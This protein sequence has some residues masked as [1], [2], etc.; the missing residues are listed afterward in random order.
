MR[1]RERLAVEQVSFLSAGAGGLGEPQGRGG[2]QVSSGTLGVSP[3]PPEMLRAR[4]SSPLAC[5]HVLLSLGRLRCLPGNHMP[6]TAI[7][8]HPAASQTLGLLSYC[9]PWHNRL[10]HWAENFQS[11]ASCHLALELVGASGVWFCARLSESQGNPHIQ[12]SGTCEGLPEACSFPRRAAGCVCR[13][14]EQPSMQGRWAR[15]GL[16]AQDG[17]EV[18]P[19]CL[20]PRSW[21]YPG[22]VW[23]QGGHSH[24]LPPH[25]LPW[26]TGSGTVRSGS[27]R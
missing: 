22:N 12:M 17:S 11:W 7:G 25:I 16:L 10:S 18:N 24:G 23:S 14:L 2:L 13:G 9:A 6:S 15:C 4:L 3:A 1:V 8:S 20:G 21:D 26:C 5:S 27:Q 19:L